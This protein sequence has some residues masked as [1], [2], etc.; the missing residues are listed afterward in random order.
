MKNQVLPIPGLF[1]PNNAK[2]EYRPNLRNVFLAAQDW[3]QEHAVHASASAK[4]KIA[5]MVID[6]QKDFCFPEGTLYVGGRSG[7]GAID[8]SI[9][10]AEF[11]YR[12]LDIITS[13]VFTMDTHFAFQ[14]F[15]PSFW[16]DAK[17]GLSPLPSITVIT[18]EQIRRGDYRPNPALSWIANGNYTWLLKYVE[19]YVA[20]L[21]RTGKYVLLLWPEH[22]LIGDEGHALVG[23]LNEARMFHSYARF[24]QS[25]VQIKGGNPLTENYSIFRPEVLL[26]HDSNVVAQKNAMFTKQLL[27]NDYVIIAGQ[28]AS[29][30]VKS[31]IDDFLEEI[32]AKDPSLARKVYILE[33]CMS[34]VVIP[35]AGL[36][37]TP[38]AEEALQKYRDAGMHVVKS[39]GP[40]ENWPDMVL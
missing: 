34:S 39:V 8:D 31:S 37:F 12:N 40:M 25:E 13:T 16:I 5:L 29:H 21:E 11:I 27:Q 26:A 20:E 14:I 15:F 19:H 4:T 10:T 23:I 17:T 3:R 6:T 9:R 36:D 32:L 35:A 38:Q 22:C 33:D 24:I 1:N 30:C 28:A 7:T 2:W 18:A